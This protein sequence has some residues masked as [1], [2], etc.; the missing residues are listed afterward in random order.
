MC[1]SASQPVGTTSNRTVDKIC[2]KVYILVPRRTLPTRTAGWYVCVVLRYH[3]RDG[4]PGR[5]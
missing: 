3:I 5:A 4:H 1:G 2:A